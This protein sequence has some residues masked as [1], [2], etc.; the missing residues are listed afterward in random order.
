MLM[1]GDGQ[2]RF[3]FGLDLIV[4]GLAAQAEISGPVNRLSV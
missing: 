1:S 3:A 2:E 4:R